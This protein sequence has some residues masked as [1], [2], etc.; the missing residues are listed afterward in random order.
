[1]GEQPTAAST[2]RVGELLALL[3]PRGVPVG[4]TS[5]SEIAQ[6]IQQLSVAEAIAL[7]FSFADPSDHYG[8]RCV[9]PSG[10]AGLPMG[11]FAWM[12][13]HGRGHRA[14]LWH[15]GETDS[16]RLWIDAREVALPT[17][18]RGD[19][20]AEPPGAWPGGTSGSLRSR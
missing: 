13:S 7:G 17:Y 3:E 5:L 4:P 11:Y 6:R 15:A 19:S 20:L 8:E 16:M 12:L 9:Y 18:P 1:M 14:L 10:P 2:A